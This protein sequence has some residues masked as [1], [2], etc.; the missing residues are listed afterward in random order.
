[1]PIVNMIAGNNTY[2]NNNIPSV[3]GRNFTHNLPNNAINIPWYAY[4]KNELP[5]SVSFVCIRSRCNPY[6]VQPITA[7]IPIRIPQLRIYRYMPDP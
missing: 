3:K 5:D 1:M 2:P 4:M 7:A 6:A